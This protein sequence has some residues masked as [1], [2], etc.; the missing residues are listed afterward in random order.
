MNA[1]LAPGGSY[2]DMATVNSTFSPCE[3]DICLID[4]I[5]ELERALGNVEQSKPSAYKDWKA[6]DL[7]ARL[8]ELKALR[9]KWTARIRTR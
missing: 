9:A 7:R 5:R 1:D 3:C 8:D 6:Q 4:R 2:D